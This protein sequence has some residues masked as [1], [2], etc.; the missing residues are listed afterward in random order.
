MSKISR[1]N[2]ARELGAYFEM[3]EMGQH[4]MISGLVDQGF[5]LIEAKR[6]YARLHKERFTKGDSLGLVQRAMRAGIWRRK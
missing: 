2:I 1:V 3:V 6:E 4:M 5:T